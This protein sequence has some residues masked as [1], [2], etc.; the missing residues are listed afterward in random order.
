M[1][2]CLVDPPRTQ[3]AFQ[4]SATASVTRE[5]DKFLAFASGEQVPCLGLTLSLVRLEISDIDLFGRTFYDRHLDHSTILS[6]V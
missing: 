3:F 1:G 2:S 6:T 4:T 5:L